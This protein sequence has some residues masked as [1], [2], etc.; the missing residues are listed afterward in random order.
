MQYFLW[1]GQCAFWQA[2]PQYRV[3]RHRAQALNVSRGRSQALPQRPHDAE[4]LSQ[5]AVQGDADRRGVVAPPV[6]LTGFN[7]S[8]VAAGQREAVAIP[9]LHARHRSGR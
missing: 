6:Q 9:G 2:R 8:E 1:V 4:S 3:V 5:Y 7:T